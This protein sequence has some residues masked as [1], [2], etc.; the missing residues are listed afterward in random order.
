MKVFGLAGWSGSGKTTLLLGVLPLLARRGIRASTMKHAHHAFDVDKP[1]K[2][3]YRHREAGATEVMVASTQR[4]A[5]MHELRDEAEPSVEELIARMTPVDLERHADGLILLTGGLAGPVARL[6]R[7]NQPGKAEDALL[8]LSTAFPGRLYVELM[9]HGLP[10]EDRVEAALLDLAYAHGLP[11]I[12]TN[13]AF[14]ADPGMYEAHDAL[15]C[16]A[17]GAYVAQRDRRRLTPEHWFKSPA[18]MRALFEDLPEAIDNTLVVARRC[19]FM[20]KKRKPILPPF[21]MEGM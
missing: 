20:V 21:V 10:D 2:D 5:L 16:V 6:L 13:E 12:A 3:S 15:I 9:R 19:A 11:L 7:D 18:A 14:F 8:R 1:G 4:W 17:E